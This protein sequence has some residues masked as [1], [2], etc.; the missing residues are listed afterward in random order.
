MIK[1]KGAPVLARG[2]T[3]LVYAHPCQG[4]CVI[5]VIRPDLVDSQARV[6]GTRKR[7]WR[8]LPRHR[9]YA[10]FAFEVDEHLALRGRWDQP[11]PCIQSVVGFAETDLGLGLVVEKLCDP[12]G[13]L[14][15]T[16]ASLIMAEGFT[17]ELMVLWQAYVRTMHRF[18]VVSQDWHP[19]NLV[20]ATDEN[21]GRRIVL[22]DGLGDRSLMRL[23]SRWLWLNRVAL[24]RKERRALRQM[25]NLAKNRS[26]DK[27]VSSGSTGHSPAR[28]VRP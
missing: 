1:L 18:G 19:G 27:A 11:I 6:P 15:P 22:I 3:K 9:R 20:R 2:T 24:R 16:V 23:R 10:E 12:G 28:E 7:L 21:Q 13:G 14:A 4:S 5:K 17:E 8:L 25:K 26:L